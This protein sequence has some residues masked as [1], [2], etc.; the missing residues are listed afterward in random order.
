MKYLLTV[1]YLGYTE[2]K[3]NGV[4]YTH[5][6][7]EEPIKTL[8]MIFKKFKVNKIN[9]HIDEDLEEICIKSASRDYGSTNI[10][11]Y[12]KCIHE[13]TQKERLPN[14]LSQLNSTLDL[15]TLTNLLSE[16]KQITR[17]PMIIDLKSK[18]V[19]VGI[20]DCESTF[21]IVSEDFKKLSKLKKEFEM[22]KRCAPFG[23][24]KISL[25]VLEK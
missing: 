15:K 9:C 3:D 17:L 16:I 11:E 18:E 24:R 14:L 21:E 12:V 7:K 19:E 6:D 23:F 5:S 4:I 22:Q 13:K 10:S 25:K 20:I 1:G 2:E 8:K